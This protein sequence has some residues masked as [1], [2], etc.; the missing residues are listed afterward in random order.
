MDL[1]GIQTQHPRW[2]ITLI[3]VLSV[4]FK[5]YNLHG[6]RLTPV[7][8]LEVIL[9]NPQDLH[10]KNILKRKREHADLNVSARFVEIWSMLVAILI[11]NTWDNIF[12]IVILN[13]SFFFYS[14]LLTYLYHTLRKHSCLHFWREMFSNVTLLWYHNGL[15]Y[16]LGFWKQDAKQETKNEPGSGLSFSPTCFFGNSGEVHFPYPNPL[17]LRASFY[18]Y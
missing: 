4:A 14:S 7:W 15:A 11:V 6:I 10:K 8:S 12:Q 3:C 5:K 1:K 16:H 18:L 13:A 9:S 2:N 17:K